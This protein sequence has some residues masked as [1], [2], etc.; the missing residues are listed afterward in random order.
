MT[1]VFDH[2]WL[3]GLFGDAGGSGS[4][5][6]GV[7]KIPG[8]IPDNPILEGDSPTP[9][10]SPRKG[11]FGLL[12]LQVPAKSFGFMAGVETANQSAK[13]GLF[14]LVRTVQN[15]LPTLVPQAVSVGAMPGRT[16]T[17]NVNPSEPIDYELLA[18]KVA[19]KIT[20][21]F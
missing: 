15:N 18:N 16:V 21:G 1:S 14:G 2:P 7:P 3:G 13:A 11:G 19:K 6:D 8:S 20:E 9:Q 10:S 5:G 4:V 17:I 12:G